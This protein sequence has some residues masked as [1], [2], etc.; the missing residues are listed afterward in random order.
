MCGLVGGLV[1]H[2]HFARAMHVRFFASIVSHFNL[3]LSRR[4]VEHLLL[5]E[6]YIRL[7][8]CPVALLSEVNERMLNQ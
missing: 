2:W 4:G 8:A 1:D 5:A 6:R 7:A 3:S